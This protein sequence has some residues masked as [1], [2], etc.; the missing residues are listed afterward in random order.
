VKTNPK[1]ANSPR[2]SFM[3]SSSEWVCAQALC[4]IQRECVQAENFLHLNA[5]MLL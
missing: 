4:I 3:S 1:T 5:A 2:K